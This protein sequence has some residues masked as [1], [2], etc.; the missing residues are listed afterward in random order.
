M[1]SSVCG[2]LNRTVRIGEL[3]WLP[4]VESGTDKC[5]VPWGVSE[6]CWWWSAVLA[7]LLGGCKLVSDE[8]DSAFSRY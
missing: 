2:E 7:I 5:S 6:G 8:A 4:G 1:V 3:T